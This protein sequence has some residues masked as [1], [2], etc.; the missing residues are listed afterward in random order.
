MKKIALAFLVVLVMASSAWSGPTFW[1][2]SGVPAPTIITSSGNI[3]VTN[4]NTMVVC[5]DTSTITIPAATAG[6]TV[7]IRN[8]P[9]QLQ[10]LTVNGRPGQY[11][12]S[13]EQGGG[14]GASGASLVSTATTEDYICLQG[15]D[16]THYLITYQAGLWNGFPSNNP[17]NINKGAK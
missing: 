13:P 8:T 1:G 16:S 9:G 14:W 17:K 3:T 12:E 6:F 11:Y 15:Y 10:E 5:T 2:S 7:C 4:T